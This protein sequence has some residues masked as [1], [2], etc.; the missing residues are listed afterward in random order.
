M[1]MNARSQVAPE[2]AVIMPI[3]NEEANISAVLHEW[4]DCLRIV[5]PNFVIFAIDDG[6]EDDT[7][8]MLASLEDELGPRLRILS[9]VNSGHG[10][11][12]REGYEVALANGAEW[13]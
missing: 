4:F 3:Y 6:S 11:S 5:C 1:P 13:I 7:G 12:C 9:K 2:L 8:R 10:L